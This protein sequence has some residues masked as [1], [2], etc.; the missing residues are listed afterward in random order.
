MKRKFYCLEDMQALAHKLG[1][2]CLSTLY[3][4]TNRKLLWRCAKD[5]TWEATPGN[6]MRGHWCRICGNERQGRAKAK[7]IEFA[8]ELAANNG[9]LC[10]SEE[11]RNNRTP[12]HWK[13]GVC[14]HE[15]TASAGSIQG[16][17]WCP[18]CVG[19]LPSE[20]GLPELQRL[21]SLKGGICLSDRYLGARAK[22]RWRCANGHEWE[23]PPYSLRSGTWCME[24]SGS[25]ALTLEDMQ[26]TAQLMGGECLSEAYSNSR[27]QLHWRCASGHEWFAVGYHVRAGHWCPTCMTGNSERI[28]KDILE[29]MFGKPFPKRKPSWLLND[30]GKR[31]ELDGYCEELKLAFEYHGVQH[32]QH[33]D[34]FHRGNKS[35]DQRKMDDE[36]KELVC[37]EYGIRLL[38]IPYTIPMNEVPRLVSDFSKANAIKIITKDPSKVPVAKMVLPERMKEMRALA[39]RKG[40]DCLSNEYIN[41]NTHLSWQC[42]KGHVWQAVPGSIQQGSW[43][44]K[45]AGRMKGDEALNSLRYIARARGGECLA[46]SYIHG[47]IKL[48]WRCSEGHVWSTSA[49]SIRDGRWCPQCAKKTMG[50]KRIGIAACHAAANERGGKCLSDSYINSDTKLLWECGDCLAQ[51][52]A[53]PYTVVRLGTWCPKCKGRRYQTTRRNREKDV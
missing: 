3:I 6:I 25:K 34:H 10:L 20:E 9:G 27:Q 31:M 26:E 48:P 19:R 5:H 18:K 22:H 39:N 42:N 29:K 23:A 46:E 11:Y 14:S 24:C 40:G 16:G 30:R 32:Y 12:M 53:I 36:R 2:Q 4:S 7:S 41:N 49:N 1:G 50:P 33:I 17:T 15:W 37:R 13:C 35:L 51:W 52:E 43:C 38:V 8:K 47:K 45:C 44:P 28:C 21:A